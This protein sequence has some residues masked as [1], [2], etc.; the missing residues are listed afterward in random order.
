MCWAVHRWWRWWGPAARARRPG[1]S[2]GTPAALGLSLLLGACSLRELD[3]LEGDAP[4][5]AAL[6]GNRLEGGG[7]PEE[8]PIEVSLAP[9]R[10][11]SV[12]AFDGECA[13]GRCME[14]VGTCEPCPEDMR[15]VRFA[16]GDAFCIDAQ[17][18]SRSDY[19]EFLQTPSEPAPVAAL[20]DPETCTSKNDFVPGD[21]TDCRG[22]FQ[23]EQS[24]SLPVTCVDLCDAM[25]YCSSKGRRVCGG[26][27][28]IKIGP[29][30][31]DKGGDEWHAACSGP[32]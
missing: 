26:P 25:A 28:G 11:P 14:E 3:D 22:A 6:A 2:A 1:G 18:V 4:E 17:E 10:D 8:E 12:C 32:V 15:L 5:G 19:A 20:R 7:A 31:V 24:P 13:E 16:T 29:R 23:S 27:S 21:G 9:T 30:R